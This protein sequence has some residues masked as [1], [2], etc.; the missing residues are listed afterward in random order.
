MVGLGDHRREDI[1]FRH[2][3]VSP[4]ARPGGKSEVPEALGGCWTA[5]TIWS[6]ILHRLD[7][8]CEPSGEAAI[9]DDLGRVIGMGIGRAAVE[10][11]AGEEASSSLMMS[12]GWQLAST[13]GKGYEM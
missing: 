10:W 1:R 6:P 2:V 3:A 4:H 13:G 9:V 5:S 11:T 7:N 12:C 8:V